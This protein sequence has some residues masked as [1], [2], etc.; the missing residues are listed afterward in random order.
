VLRTAAT[1]RHL[2]ANGEV[3][4]ITSIARDARRIAVPISSSVNV[5][6]AKRSA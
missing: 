2:L 5:R 6:C 4:S 3:V 1:G